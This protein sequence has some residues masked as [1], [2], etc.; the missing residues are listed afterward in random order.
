LQSKFQEISLP[1]EETKKPAAIQVNEVE[2]FN[3]SACYE[4]FQDIGC[5]IPVEKHPVRTFIQS[6]IDYIVTASDVQLARR[7]GMEPE[8]LES[9]IDIIEKTIEFKSC[10]LSK[11]DL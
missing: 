4:V 11:M 2:A 5:V 9:L 10:C 8:A 3:T 6:N 1:K 7:I